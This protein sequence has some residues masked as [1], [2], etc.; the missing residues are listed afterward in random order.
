MSLDSE[1]ASNP[2]LC[3]SCY[4]EVNALWKRIFDVKRSKED[5]KAQMS[6][7]EV[8]FNHRKRHR[9]PVNSPRTTPLKG[10]QT[11]PSKQ[12][13]KS[14]SPSLPTP[15]PSIQSRRL[16]DFPATVVAVRPLTSTLATPL[17][18]RIVPISGPVDEPKEELCPKT[19]LEVCGF[20]KDNE[21][22]YNCNLTLCMQE[23]IA[24]KGSR[25]INVGIPFL[26]YIQYRR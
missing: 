10:T 23:L 20:S 4:Q 5:L 21:I 12:L 2:K 15:R 6:R 3:R 17:P 26:Y 25:V 16:L 14:N 9:D 13:L 1:K 24:K 8:F 7:A 19:S 22:Q 18:Q 11:P